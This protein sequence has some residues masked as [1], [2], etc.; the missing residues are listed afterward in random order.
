[1]N[2]NNETWIRAR[3]KCIPVETRRRMSKAAFRRWRDPRARWYQS[4]TMERVWARRK[5]AS[6]RSLE[7]HNAAAETLAVRLG[8]ARRQEGGQK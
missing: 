3:S 2:I 4:V 1:M 5:Q 7:A 8:K 6:A